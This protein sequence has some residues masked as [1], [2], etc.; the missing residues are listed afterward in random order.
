MDGDF[1]NTSVAMQ[2]LSRRD[3][4]GSDFWTVIFQAVI[5]WEFQEASNY[6]YCL[7]DSGSGHILHTSLNDIWETTIVCALEGARS[8][9]THTGVITK[10]WTIAVTGAS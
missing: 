10:I 1:W 7:Q 4:S 3:L 6:Q 2:G 5:C 9:T 8:L